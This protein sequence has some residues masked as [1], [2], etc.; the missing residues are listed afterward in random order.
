M[1][2]TNCRISQISYKEEKYLPQSTLPTRIRRTQ[3]FIKK[4]IKRG[5]EVCGTHPLPVTNVLNL[6]AHTLS[7]EAQNLFSNFALT[8]SFGLFSTII[9]VNNFVVHHQKSII[10]TPI[11][12]FQ[13]DSDNMTLMI[14]ILF[15]TCVH[16]I[17]MSFLLYWYQIRLRS[18][19]I[20]TS[21]L[22]K[23]SNFY[24]IQL[25]G[26]KLDLF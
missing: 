9:D 1:T 22:L 20:S 14:L 12:W 11:Y 6:S 8:Q 10:S 15:I 18:R 7:L 19:T 24:P 21:F 4:R 25:R 17:V 16:Y 13:P 3:A 23:K 5:K 2:W 26:D